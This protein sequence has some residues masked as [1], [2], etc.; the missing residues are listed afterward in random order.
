MGVRWTQVSFEIGQFSEQ[1]TSMLR[2]TNLLVTLNR[3][4]ARNPDSIKKIEEFLARDLEVTAPLA[5]EVAVEEG[6]P[7]GRAL[8]NVL[9]RHTDPS[10]GDQLSH[11]I[12]DRTTALREVAVII[13]QQLVA[14]SSSIA[15]VAGV[16]QLPAKFHL[17]RRWADNGQYEPALKEMADLVHRLELLRMTAPHAVDQQLA[18][19]QSNYAALLFMRGRLEDALTAAQRANDLYEALV[20]GSPESSTDELAANLNNMSVIL[21]DMGLWDE[22]INAS[23]R[24]LTLREQMP[25]EH[26]HRLPGIAT[27]LKGLA[28]HLLHLKEFGESLNLI[29]RAIAIYELLFE[30]DPDAWIAELADS[31]DARARILS[32]TG[33]INEAIDAAERAVELYQRIS[34]SHRRAFLPDLALAEEE[35]AVLFCKAARFHEAMP[36]ASAAVTRWRTLPAEELAVFN[37]YFASA[38][39]TL[40]SVSIKCDIEEQSLT[41][42]ME[43]LGIRLRLASIDPRLFRADLAESLVGVSVCLTILGRYVEAIEFSRRGVQLLS[44]LVAR[45]R[46]RYLPQLASSALNL[47]VQL[48]QCGEFPEGLFYLILSS[49]L[50]DEIELLFP[51][52]HNRNR[53]KG[54]IALSRAFA[55]EGQFHEALRVSRICCELLEPLYRENGH[56]WQSEFEFALQTYSNCLADVGLLADSLIQTRRVVVLR[57]ALCESEPGNPNLRHRLA[58]SLKNLSARLEQSGEAEEAIRVRQEALSVE[59]FLMQ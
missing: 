4:A 27:S 51:G 8:A 36:L 43:S 16:K 25:S 40:A 18:S 44:E 48:R 19:A 3:I 6:D 54:M 12:P 17:A 56:R 35:L 49:K 41:L 34:A 26:S 47:G 13:A 29:E 23:R 22:A 59:W 52:M 9:E 33:E 32:H 55:D 20:Y 10:L 39:H 38:L 28:R 31:L 5:I 15:D 7:M 42:A 2:A 24:S 50:H 57:R 58:D 14:I 11:L 1:V 30:C 46:A 45:D 53:L 37:G 21:A